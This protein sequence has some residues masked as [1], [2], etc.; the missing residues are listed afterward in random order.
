MTIERWS[1]DSQPSQSVATRDTDSWVN[2]LKPVVELAEGICNTEFVPSSLRGN[3]GKTTAAILYGREMGLPPMTALGSVHVISGTASMSAAAKRALI[4]ANGHQI[5]TVEMTAE[6]CVIKGR[7][8]GEGEWQTF[9]YTM[10]EAQRSGD[11]KKNANYQTRPVEMLLARASGRMANAMFADVIKGLATTE[12]V[13]DEA[14]HTVELA[15]VEVAPDPQPAEA[16]RTISRKRPAAAAPTP[17]PATDGP[18]PAAKRPPLRKAPSTPEPASEPAPAEPQVDTLP[19]EDGVIDAQ[20]VE[21]PTEMPKWQTGGLKIAHM[22]WN[23]LGV[24]DRAEQLFYA[25]EVAGR[26]VESHKDLTQDELRALN[27][28]LER[29]RDLEAVNAAIDAKRQE[30]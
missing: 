16:P 15:S 25:G 23:R 22:H 6:R 21:E 26:K 8:A 20:V 1:N 5:V 9:S 18:P 19:D 13:M 14:R 11:A 3:V 28:L 10:A 24:T 27:G 17:E 12:E 30:G 29:S 2:V 4:Q 7:R